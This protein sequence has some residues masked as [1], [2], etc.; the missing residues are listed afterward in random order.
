[1]SADIQSNLDG[2]TAAQMSWTRL[3][4]RTFSMPPCARNFLIFS[5]FLS[6]SFALYFDT[7]FMIVALILICLISGD[8]QRTK[9]RF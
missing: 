4:Q 9:S 3:F 7:N 2:R 5:W 1:M 6:E 8:L